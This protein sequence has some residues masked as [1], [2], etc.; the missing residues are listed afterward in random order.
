MNQIRKDGA[1]G[2][3]GFAPALLSA[4]GG[5]DLSAGVPV[6]FAFVETRLISASIAVAAAR[7]GCSVGGFYHS[8][9]LDGSEIYFLMTT[10]SGILLFYRRV[11][12]L[13]FRA[14]KMTIALS[15]LVPNADDL[16][17]LEVEEVAGVF[18]MHLNSYQSPGGAPIAQN[19]IIS[20]FNL[21]NDLNANPPY[22]DRKNEVKLVLMEAW[23]WLQSE[24]FLVKDAEQSA[25]WYFISRRGKRLNTLEEFDAYRKA[26]LFPKGQLHPLMSAKVYPAFLRGEYDTAVFQAYREIEV[27]VRS[28]G[29]FSD[30]LVGTT[31]MRE[32]F[33]P[34]NPNKPTV[35][36]GK[37]TDTELPSA[38]QE[39]MMNLFAGAIGLYKNPQSHRNVPTEAIDAAE[40]IGFASHLLRVI[41]KI[42][43][44]E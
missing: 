12:F 5:F 15:T 42:T 29:K 9:R 14:E 38:E 21:V 11:L 34:A 37:L 10:H 43:L 44:S 16:L 7:M 2:N 30:D 17:S 19:N 33:R 6:C 36:P 41:D 39:A 31:L 3:A 20:L 13:T 27:A 28:V 32:A 1:P 35:V 24:G 18:L 4:A 26:N 23:N 40:V 8:A 25:D 22:P